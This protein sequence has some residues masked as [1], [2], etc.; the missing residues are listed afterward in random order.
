MFV[1]LTAFRRVLC[2]LTLATPLLGQAPSPLPAKADTTKPGG[3]FDRLRFRV[4]GPAA[5]SGRIDDFAVFEKNPAIFYVGSATGGVWKTV[6]QGTTFTPVF[7]GQSVSS[8]GD[9]TIAPNDPNV[10]WVGT[11]ESNNRQ[12][13]SW[14]DGVYKSTDGGKIWKNA[15]L[16]ESKQIPGSWWTRSTTTWYTSPRWA[17]SGRRAASGESTRPATAE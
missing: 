12:S 16:R 9:V 2:L 14:G 10:V 17:I 5:P 6:N 15:G 8:I 7:D 3:P 11:G 13:S 4:V 1:P